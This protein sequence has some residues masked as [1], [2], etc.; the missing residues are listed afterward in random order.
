MLKNTTGKN[1]TLMLRGMY[2]I[3]LMV[4]GKK[5]HII[6]LYMFSRK[7]IETYFPYIENSLILPKQNTEKNQT[8][9]YVIINI[10]SNATT[11][12]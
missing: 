2:K 3:M 11:H 5:N 10:Y 12:R 7:N 6:R 8:N 4:F 1:N 9:I